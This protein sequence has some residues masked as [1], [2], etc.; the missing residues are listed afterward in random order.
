MDLIQ[1]SIIDVVAVSILDCRSSQR[2][3]GF[4]PKKNYRSCHALKILI[5]T[6][7][8]NYFSVVNLC[9]YRLSPQDHRAGKIFQSYKSW[10][11]HD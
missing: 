10:R 1:H 9:C 6:E 2:D 8:V 3:R 5:P 11:N 4:S 7:Q